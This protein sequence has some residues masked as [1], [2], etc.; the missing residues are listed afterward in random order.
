MRA[1]RHPEATLE[2]GEAE[3]ADSVEEP[4]VEEERPGMFSF[5]LS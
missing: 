2:E 3:E 1:L 5:S 4:L